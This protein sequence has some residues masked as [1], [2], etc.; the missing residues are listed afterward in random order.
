MKNGTVQIEAFESKLLAGNPLGDPVL[1]K[2]PVYLPPSYYNSSTEYPV[3][4]CLAGY[5]GGARSWLN[6]QAWIPSIDE[7][8]DA[9]IDQGMPEMVLV[10][11]DC[12]TI[13]GGSQYLDS[14]AVGRYRSHLLQEILPLVERKYRVKRDRRFR[15][16][17]GKSSGGYGA[18]TIAMEHPDLFSTVACH[19]GDMFFEYCYLSEFPIACRRLRQL[20]GLNGFFQ[21]FDELQKNGKEI[22]AVLDTVAMSACYSPNPDAPHLIDLPF[23]LDTGE[24]KPDIWRKWKEKDPVEMIRKNPACLKNFGYIYID[25]GMRDEFALDVGARIFSAELER[26]RIPHTHEEFDDGHFNIQYRYDVSLKAIAGYFQS[27]Q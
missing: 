10:F 5:T 1:R 26:N 21:K 6:F 14:I 2:L 16:V 17:M 12:F 7:R 19:S 9:L 11:P 24:L 25:C 23:H 13:L 22:H 3:V 15:G 27:Q 8:A 18:I 20:G 4:L